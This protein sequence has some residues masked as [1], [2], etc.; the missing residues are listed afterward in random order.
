MPLSLRFTSEFTAGGITFNAGR[1][2]F[3]VKEGRPA[4][5]GLAT[6]LIQVNNTGVFNLSGSTIGAIVSFTLDGTV[7]SETI[8]AAPA[9]GTNSLE[10]WG[11]LLDQ[12][13]ADPRFSVVN[14]SDDPTQVRGFAQITATSP[15]T[16]FEV[17]TDAGLGLRVEFRDV[18]P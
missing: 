6:G 17:F 11:L 7:F 10:S 14:R 4:V 1:F 13:D 2:K 8:G 15:N 18:S 9:E 5:P 12:V 16:P 3:L